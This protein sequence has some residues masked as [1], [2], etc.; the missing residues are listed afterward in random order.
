[1]NSSLIEKLALFA[2]LS[3]ISL[4]AFAGDDLPADTTQALDALRTKHDLPGLAIVVVQGGEI[5]ERA[6]VGVRKSGEAAT[7]TTN[8]VFHIGSCTKSLTATLAALLIEDGKLKWNSTIAG[9]FPEL[10]GKMD[11]RYES[12]S[13]EQLLTHHGGVPAAPPAAAWKRA[14]EQHCTPTQQ[15]AE[16]IAAVLREPPQAEP[17]TKMIYSNQG[18]AIAGAMLEKLTGKPWE[19][20][21]REKLFVPLKM[22]TAGFGSPGTPGKLDQPWGHTRK[23]DLTTPTQLD[24]PPA[25]APAG[26]VHCSLDDLARFVMA[27]LRE[28]KGESL[29]PPAMW[30]KLHAPAAGGDYA[31]G[32]VCVKRDWAGGTALMHNGSN[33][34]W[35]LVMWLAPEKDFAVIAATNIAGPKASKAC[36]EAAGHLIGK[37]LKK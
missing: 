6:A 35:Y 28:G 30:R 5:H 2:A 29:L 24:N 37:W 12:V 36:D 22:K 7:L 9:V 8:D 3:A 20:L 19:Q 34:M 25:I 18:Y 15:R 1:M 31:C 10:K 11:A 26:R 4:R 32:W 17:G 23:A 27:H 33:I 14:W 13:L 21:I 16:F